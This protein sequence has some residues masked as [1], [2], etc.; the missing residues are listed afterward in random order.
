MEDINFILKQKDDITFVNIEGILDSY[1]AYKLSEQIKSLLEQKRI[2]I[3]L[4]LKNVEYMSSAGIGA[5]LD[6]L[7]VIRK[8]NGDIGLINVSDKIMKILD[9]CGL[10]KMMQI[11]KNEEEAGKLFAGGKSS[12]AAFPRIVTCPSCGFKSEVNNSEVYKCLKCDAIFQVR[13]DGEVDYIKKGRNIKTSGEVRKIKLNFQSDIGVLSSIRSLIGNLAG[14]E[15]F[16]SDSVYDIELAVDE[17][18]V[19][20]IEHAYNL[21]KD[22]DIELEIIFTDEMLSIIIMDNGKFVSVDSNEA[23]SKVKKI[24][25]R[26]RGTFI[27]KNVMDKVEYEKGENNM[28]K[29]VMI[30]YRKGNEIRRFQPLK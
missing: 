3:I 19:N 18:L 26:G 11:L 1:T 16:N 2:K 6:H 7:E 25:K 23:D 9:V 15:G 28:N 5:I 4:D 17:S 30:K 21:E 13:I 22:H 12:I 20:V 10:T 8:N 27:M 24:L 14:R 29:L